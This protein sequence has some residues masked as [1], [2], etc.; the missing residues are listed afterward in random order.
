[1]PAVVHSPS[2]VTD[3]LRG[4]AG[5]LAGGVAVVIAM[6]DGVPHAATASSGVVASHDPPLLAV[7]FAR[8]SRMAEG[9]ERG[10]RYTFNLL[11]HAD[12]AVARR[13]ANPARASGWPAFAGLD[14]LARDPDPPILPHASAWFDCRLAQVVPTGDHACFLGEVLACARDPAATPLIHHRGRLHALGPS[15]APPRWAGISDSDLSS[16]W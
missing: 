6:V 1:M 7:F 5:H 11:R 3:D 8:G 12:H 16:V 4:A 10:E 9:L 15:V 13:F 14:L 2:R